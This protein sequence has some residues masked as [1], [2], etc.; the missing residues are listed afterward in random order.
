MNK[1]EENRRL[2]ENIFAEL[3]RGNTAPFVDALDDAVRWTTPGSSVWSRSFA[4]KASVLNDLLGPVRA[5][6]VKRVQLTVRQVLADRD[7]V[8]VEAKGRAT[9]K[10]GLPY[11]NDYCFLYRLAGGK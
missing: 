11:E 5:Q 1:I 8:V 2:I 3:E 4:G 7:V 9:T 10:R 6:L